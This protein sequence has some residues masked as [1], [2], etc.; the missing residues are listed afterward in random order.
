MFPGVAD[1]AEDLDRGDRRRWPAGRRT[2]WPAARRDA[3][4][5]RRRRRRPTA[6]GSRRCGPARPFRTCRRTGAGL[7]GTTPIGW[8]NCC[9]TL[10][11]STARSMTARAAPSA[12]AAR[13]DEHVVDQG[14]RLRPPADGVA[15]RCA[16]ASSSVTRNCLRVWSIPRSGVTARC[17]GV[18]L[19]REKPCAVTVLGE[20]QQDVGGG[21]VGTPAISPRSDDA[22]VPLGVR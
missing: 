19:H 8:P 20:H 12:S 1:A 10:A 5:A 15:S 22:A 2:P 14:L 4:R 7:P 21:D 17:P 16:G 13:G 11:Y 9:R 3:A 18:G 6:H